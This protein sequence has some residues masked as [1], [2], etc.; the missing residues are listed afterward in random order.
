MRGHAKR[1]LLLAPIV[2][3]AACQDPD[4]GNPCTIEVA[5]GFSLPTPVELYE[6]GGGEYFET[7]NLECEGLV[8][9]L[10]PAAN[11]SRYSGGAYCS[12]PCVSND[13]C[14]QSETGLVCRQ[15]ILDALFLAQLPDDVRDTYLGDVQFSSFC[16][17][18]R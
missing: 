17:V 13:D 12:K 6:Q 15:M 4:V 10:S 9:V 11:G 2:A 18:P 7:G 16:A 1:I 5:D 3:L 14:F 8:C